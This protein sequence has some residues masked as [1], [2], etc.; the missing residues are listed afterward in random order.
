MTAN[1]MVELLREH[2]GEVYRF[3]A[4]APKNDAGYKGPWDCAEAASWGI[5]Q[6][7]GKLF[8]C[9]NNDGDPATADAYTGYFGRDVNKG[10]LKKISI[11]EAKRTVGA[12][13]LRLSAGSTIGHIACSKGDGGTIEAAST[14]LGFTELKVDGRRWDYG[15]VVPGLVQYDYNAASVGG[16]NV[17]SPYAAPA[18]LI[19]RLTAPMMRHPM[20]E[21]LGD[22]LKL[23]GLYTKKVDDIYG[24]GMFKAVCELQ[25]SL[26]LIVDGEAGRQVFEA[27][28]L[29]ITN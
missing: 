4:V 26:G 14:K 18:G 22:K 25:K 6:A 27:I 3:G 20:V 21:V 12:F 1:E 24:E 23:L 17:V 15:F 19:L 10:L 8:G 2:N 5:Y 16:V 7:T 28:G 11:D 29:Q 13:L 9:D